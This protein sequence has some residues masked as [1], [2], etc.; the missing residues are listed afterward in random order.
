[1]VKTDP[2]IFAREFSGEILGL[3][4]N[5]AS[6]ADFFYAYFNTLITDV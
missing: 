5:V 4:G 1:M 6:I 3:V 2:N